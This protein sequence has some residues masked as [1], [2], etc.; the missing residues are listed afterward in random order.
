[1]VKI[2]YLIAGANGS[3]KTTIARELLS[4]EKLEF[5]N[6]DEIAA[7][8]NPDITKVRVK[9]GKEFFRKL[10]KI[11]ELNKSVAIETTLAGQAHN[12]IIKKYKNKD[13]I[14]RLAYVFLANTEMCID[15]IKVRVIKGGH[16]VPDADVLRRYI[17][18]KINF[19]KII[20]SGLIDEW[21]LYYNGCE[22][23]IKVAQGRPNF[24]DISD[25][26]LYNKFIRDTKNE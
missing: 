19:L 18:S 16:H 26:D 5:L 11:I 21:T 2:L 20:N 15:R 9:A 8:L 6:A 13:Y 3:G 14:I 7:K 4:E 17:R 24:I 25:Q 12:K 1:M 23:Y 22:T 10:A